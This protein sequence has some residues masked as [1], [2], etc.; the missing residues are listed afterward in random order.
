MK[1]PAPADLQAW[2]QE[3]ASDPASLSFLPLA[4]AYRKQGRRDA[5]LRL[6]LRGLQHHSSNIE[7]HAL[8]A[9]LYFESGQRVKAYDEWS[10]V[11]ML[12]PDNFDA[13]R[14]M[15]FY[16]LEQQD[17]VTAHKHLTRAA[18][19]K[20]NDPAVQEGLRMLQTMAQPAAAA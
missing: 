2:S 12:D 10:M 14:G 17:Q 6:C 1:A 20:P 7:A 13:L 16:F 4:R 11:L 19:L 9:V 5:A 8:L 3:V 18:Q 15:G